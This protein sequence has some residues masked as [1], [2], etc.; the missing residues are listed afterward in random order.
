MLLFSSGEG[1]CRRVSSILE[2]PSGPPLDQTIPD[3]LCHPG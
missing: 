2:L 3:Q 1:P